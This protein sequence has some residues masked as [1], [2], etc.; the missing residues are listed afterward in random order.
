MKEENS[1]F[2][3]LLNDKEI[4]TSVKRANAGNSNV[5]GDKISKLFGDLMQILVVSAIEKQ[6]NKNICGATFDGAFVGMS[7]FLRKSLEN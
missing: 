5:P 2:K 1:G 3:Y 4:K 6:D 7:G